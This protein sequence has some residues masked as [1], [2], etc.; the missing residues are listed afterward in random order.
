MNMAN[1]ENTDSSHYFRC[2]KI[3]FTNFED[4]KLRVHTALALL[5]LN[6]SQLFENNIREQAIAHKL[7]SYLS[8]V[9]QKFDVDCEYNR[10][11]PD[12]NIKRGP[13]GGYITLDIVVHSRGK[14][15]REYNLLH[16]EIKKDNEG[17]EDC[18]RLQG[19]T[20]NESKLE[21]KYR[22]GLFLNFKKQDSQDVYVTTKWFEDGTEL[23][24]ETL[25]LNLKP[26]L[27]GPA[28][29]SQSHGSAS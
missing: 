25:D 19:T 28:P 15:E 5:K 14:I 27:L 7:A 8:I 16:V 12:E 11:G 23:T 2:C 10:V 21:Y 3:D 6:D 17:K 9:F 24:H 13:R 1:P 4:I 20:K 29:A 26:P 22:Y 18:K